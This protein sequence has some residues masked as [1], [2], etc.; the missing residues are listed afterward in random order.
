M[1]ALSRKSRSASATSAPSF[2]PLS[3]FPDPNQVRLNLVLLAGA[4]ILA[5]GVAAWGL[6]QQR[7]GADGTYSVEVVGPGGHLVLA[8]NVTLAS[9][10]ALSALEAAAAEQGAALELEEYPGM[11]TYVR[12]IGPYRASG[13]NGWVYE[14]H[15]AG[16]WLSGDRSAS[17]FPLE[18]ADVLRWA[19]TESGG[20]R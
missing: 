19:W 14:V 5:G 16:A 10:T 18:R 9:A 6:Q 15:R 2:F 8:T 17:F 20:A 4:L 13:A 12:A 11:G 3:R 1:P 7:A